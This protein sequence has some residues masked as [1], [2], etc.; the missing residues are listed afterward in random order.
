MNHPATT[1]PTWTGNTEEAKALQL[2]LREHIDLSPL[3]HP[4]KIIAGADI[5]MNRGSPT[6]HA[7]IVVLEYPSMQL[8][9]EQGYS[10][11]IPF[12]Y[13]PG[14]LS[15]REVPLL[16]KAWQKLKHVPDVVM[17]DGHGIMHPR[18]FGVACHFGLA[19]NKPTLGCAKKHLVGNYD[20]PERIKG[21]KHSVRYKERHVG[22]VLCSRDNCNPVYISPGTGMSCEQSLE[23]TQRSLTHYR[24][25]EPTRLAHAFVN[26]LRS[27]AG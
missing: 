6:G 26:R 10:G 16:L 23:L 13:I 15:F 4:P 25:P 17:L 20:Q 9:E 1:F 14:Y 22:Y 12:P 5:S 8:L 7:G 18:F 3:P 2:K 11:T 27:A 24:L 21:N 19:V